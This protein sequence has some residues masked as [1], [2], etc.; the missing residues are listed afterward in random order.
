MESL[1]IEKNITIDSMQGTPLNQVHHA[2]EQ[3]SDQ[4]AIEKQNPIAR[5]ARKL[6]LPLSRRGLWNLKMQLEP[7]DLGKVDKLKL[8]KVSW[9]LT[10]WQ[11]VQRPGH[12][13]GSGGQAD[14]KYRLT[15]VQVESVQVSQGN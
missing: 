7:E 5:S 10:S 14:T 3:H 13:N 11:L 12:A 4:Q 15:N 6:H 2:P 1:E 9:S 8:T